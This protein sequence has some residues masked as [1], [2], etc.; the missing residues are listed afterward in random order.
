MSFI[1]E[2][3]NDVY[4]RTSELAS[5][6]TIPLRYRLSPEHKE[7][8]IKYSVPS[9]YAL[10]EGFVKNAFWLYIKEINRLAVPINDVHI[11]LLTHTLSSIDKLSLENPRMSYKTKKEFIEFYQNTICQPLTISDKLPTKSNVDFTVINEM[12]QRFNL[13]QL[14]KSFESGLKKLLKFRNSIA[15]GDISIPVKVEN[16]EFFSKLVIDLMAEIL[17]NIEDGYTRRTYLKTI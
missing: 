2:I 7:L 10:W 4:W 11:D 17:L 6:K 5:L 1:D 14:P 15:H 9:I 16:I 12:L 8:L 13:E 3:N